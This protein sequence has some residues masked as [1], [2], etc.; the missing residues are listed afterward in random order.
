[1]WSH[2][3]TKTNNISALGLSKELTRGPP[4]LVQLTSA[5]SFI[6]RCMSKGHDWSNG[7]SKNSKK[8]FQKL[9]ID[10]LRGAFRRLPAVLEE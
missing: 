3:A 8:S 5:L 7:R 9:F 1:L 4:E 10:I 2:L 6:E